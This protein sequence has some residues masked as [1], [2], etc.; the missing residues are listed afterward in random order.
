[1][2]KILHVT[3]QYPGKTGSGIYLK[4]IMG[5][6]HKKGY[7]QALIAGVA[8]DDIIELQYTE[9]FYPVV[10]NSPMIPF[11]VLGMSDNMPYES[12]KYSNI[13][14]T[15]IEKWEVEFKRVVKNAIEEFKPDLILSHHLWLSTS[16]LTEIAKDIKIIGICHGTDL[17]QIEKS[18][19][20]KARVINA[21]QRLDK[22]FALNNQQKEKISSVYGI[23]SDKIVVVGGGYNKDIFYFKDEKNVEKEKKTKDIRIIYAG[24][25]SYSKGLMSLLRVMDMIKDKYNIKLFLAGTGSGLEEVAIKE[26]GR[27]I[28]ESVVFLGSLKQSDLGKSFRDSDIF[29][30]PS[31]YEGLPLVV[32]ESL[33]SGL[34]VVTTNIPGLKSYLGEEINESGIIEYVELPEMIEIDQ[35][36]E[37][38][39]ANFE[40]R[41][42]L[43][44]ELQIEKLLKSEEINLHT[45]KKIEALS[46][47]GVFLKMEKHL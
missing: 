15:M 23:K 14:E 24:K 32:I 36:L 22:V 27:E 21:C 13:S 12:M 37:S 35:P 26:Y 1:M 45:R 2:K 34:S 42:K 4:S 19:R 17:R 31:F 41:L 11:P 46:W 33:A 44:I 47:E 43:K 20:Y 7:S 30:L 16:F 3:A 40:D 38:E 5:E 18:T 8:K 6:C 29:V 10:F 28:G 25:L 9:E 39:I